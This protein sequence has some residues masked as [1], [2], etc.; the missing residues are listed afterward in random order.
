MVK[1]WV[2][3]VLDIVMVM[4]ILMVLYI[5]VLD[6]VMVMVI[7]MVLYIMDHRWHCS[8]I[9]PWYINTIT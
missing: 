1:V 4:V 3:G 2:R 6:I 5:K 8:V 7:L 9:L